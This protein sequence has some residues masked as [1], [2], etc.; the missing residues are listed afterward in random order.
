MVKYIVKYNSIHLNLV[1]SVTNLHYVH[2][3]KSLF[4][5]KSGLQYICSK[6]SWYQ[7]KLLNGMSM[8]IYFFVT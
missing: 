4:F 1:Y 2:F 6:N 5:N 3:V 8:R 7:Y